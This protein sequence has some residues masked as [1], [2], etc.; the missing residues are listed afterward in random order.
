MVLV[1]AVIGLLI[2]W[3]THHLSILRFGPMTFGY[4]TFCRVVWFW[5]VIVDRTLSEHPSNSSSPIS[6]S[7]FRGTSWRNHHLTRRRRILIVLRATWT[8][9][10]SISTRASLLLGF[11]GWKRATFLWR[12]NVRSLGNA[13]LQFS[14][15]LIITQMTRITCDLVGGRSVSH[16][17]WWV[18]NLYIFQTTV[19]PLLPL[20]LVEFSSSAFD[21]G[22]FQEIILSLI[23]QRWGR[24]L[25]F[26]NQALLMYLFQIVSYGLLSRFLL[27]KWNLLQMKIS[28]LTTQ[29]K[30]LFVTQKTPFL[31]NSLSRL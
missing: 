29:N 31:T 20:C 24:L 2:M 30:F 25:F 11:R 23:C 27:K 1:Q 22:R 6:S 9:V 4:R 10:K 13:T 17:I 18:L 3:W 12:R 19:P 14:T 16:L 26:V 7:I 5:H 21:L 28:G 15:S 8:I